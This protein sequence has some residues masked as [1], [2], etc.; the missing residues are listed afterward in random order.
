MIGQTI[1]GVTAFI[2]NAEG[3]VLLGKKSRA[4]DS[5]LI[6]KWVTP[7]GKVEFQE[8]LTEAIRREV[9]EETGVEITVNGFLSANELMNG[10]HHYV[11]VVFE[12][13]S[14]SPASALKA[15]DDLS[16]VRWFDPQEVAKMIERNELTPLTEQILDAAYDF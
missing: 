2:T 14:N 5:S 6:D 9:L 4:F 12:A 3:Q 15:A 16:E 11:F 1:L 13:E 10:K 7:G 8:P